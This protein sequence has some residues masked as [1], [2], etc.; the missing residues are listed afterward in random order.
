MDRRASRPTLPHL[1]IIQPFLGEQAENHKIS[2]HISPV[3]DELKLEREEATSNRFRDSRAGDVSESELNDA[4]AAPFVSPTNIKQRYLHDN[5]HDDHHHDNT[6][7]T[8]DDHHHAQRDDINVQ[9]NGTEDAEQQQR[10][11][12]EK[13]KPLNLSKDYHTTHT[14]PQT[15]SADRSIQNL[16]LMKMRQ[17]QQEEEKLKKKH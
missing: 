12:L 2:K 9:H 4:L 10:P 11:S 3:N 17:H 8:H 7:N 16:C 5:T 1:P 6:D 14:T 13:Q 15:S